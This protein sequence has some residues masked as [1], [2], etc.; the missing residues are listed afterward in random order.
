MHPC[1]NIATNFTNVKTQN[2][3]TNEALKVLC[4]YDEK[5]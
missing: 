2:W 5:I 3:I 1:K 4:K